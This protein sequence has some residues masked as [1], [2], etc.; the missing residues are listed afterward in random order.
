MT[1]MHANVRPGAGSYML[2][3]RTYLHRILHMQESCCLE[4]RGSSLFLFFLFR[5]GAEIRTF[6]QSG[7]QDL[8]TEPEVVR[9]HLEQFVGVNVFD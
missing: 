6:S 9:C 8:L 2:V 1:E 5:S 4:I 3:K 7:I